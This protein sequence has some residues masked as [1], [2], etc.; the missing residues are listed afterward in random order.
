MKGE[1]V[2]QHSGPRNIMKWK[3]R[4]EVEMFSTY[5]GEEARLKRKKCRQEN[6]KPVSVLDLKVYIRR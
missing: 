6:R 2:A 1:P 3:D 4:K 5:H